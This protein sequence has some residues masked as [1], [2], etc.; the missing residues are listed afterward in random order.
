MI[1]ITSDDAEQ[2]IL[3]VQEGM[4][5]SGAKDI[6]CRTL[7][8]SFLYN[9]LAKDIPQYKAKVGDKVEWI[10]E[11]KTLFLGYIETLPYNT[12]DDTISVTCQ[13]L[14]SRVMRSKYI[15]RMRGT[16]NE[17]TNNICG[18]FGI[19]NGISVDNSHIHNIVSTGDLTYYDALNTALKTMFDNYTLYMD[20]DTLKLAETDTVATFEIGKKVRSSSFSQ[21]MSD[22]VTRVLIIDNNGNLLDAVENAENLQKYGLFQ[23]VYNYNK[24]VRNNLAEA[25]KL[26]KGV[27]NEGSI[28]VNNDNNCI[29]GR[30]ITVREPVNGFEGTFE[31][32][33]DRHTI[34]TG[35]QYM[36]LEIKHV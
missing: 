33:T 12:D 17:L 4:T 6:G 2:T 32:Q 36:E 16:L 13:D 1:K 15:G 30:F 9:P 22:M 7:E 23:E 31:I 28:I 35:N 3:T 10:E 14:L 20:G 8:F 24:D 19:K 34:E 21:S 11:D 5:W 29:S 27:S 26:L 18:A 25:Q